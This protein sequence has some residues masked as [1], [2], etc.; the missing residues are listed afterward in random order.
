VAAP[1]LF[2]CVLTTTCTMLKNIG[3]ELPP[4]ER[5]GKT[6]DWRAGAPTWFVF[7]SSLPAPWPANISQL[8]S[9]LIPTHPLH[10][11][12]IS[13]LAINSLSRA[14]TKESLFVGRT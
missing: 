5:G 13:V 12:A 14:F 6:Y 3:G 1:N 4:S 7:V 10:P 2:V 11:M 9:H 8:H